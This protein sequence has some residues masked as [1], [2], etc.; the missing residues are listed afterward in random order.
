M[1]EKLLLDCTLRDGGYVNDWNFGHDNLVSVFERVVDAGVDM[2]EIGFLDERRSFDINRSIMPDTDAV[3]RIYGRLDRKNTMVVGMIDYGTCGLEHIRPCEESFLDGIRVIFKK[4]LREPALE[5]CRAL[6]ELGYKVFAQ[7]VSVTSYSDGELLDLIRLANEVRPYAVSMV[8]TYG[9]MHQN[10]L[11]HYFDL[12]NKNLLPEIGL[13][14]HAHNNFQM[15]YANCIAMLSNQIE[16]S[17]VVDGSIYGM[18]KSAGNAPLELIAMHMNNACGKHYQISQ[19]LETIDSNILQFY[20]PATWGYNMF[21]YIAA[22]NDCH[23]SY[24]SYLMNK[25]T[26]SIKSINEILSRLQGDKRLLY[27]RD[28]V[29]SLYVDYQN[30]EVDDKADRKRLSELLADKELLLIGPGTTVQAQRDR[31][32][33]YLSGKHPVVISINYVPAGLK[34]DFIFLSN[35]KRYVQLAS[36]LTQERYTVI[37]TSNVTGTSEGVFAFRLNF[38]SLMDP[39]AEIC[40]N[41]L[42]MLLKALISI[43]CRQVTLAGFDGYSS[44]ASNYFNMSM[45]YDFVKKKADYLNDYTIRFLREISGKLSVRF[46]TDSRYGGADGQI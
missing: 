29:E 17:I 13:G 8:D 15:G 38:S 16:R 33:R 45:E 43:G 36:R 2:I 9:L 42:V 20:H 10:N 3:A 25:R 30:H 5:F 37:A 39:D 12:L 14:Y 32:D 41:S 46:L 26:L 4:H 24:V 1:G 18:G 27:D 31:I 35:A 34:P 19:I 11:M 7:L 6:K 28:Y 21:Y 22:S 23:P 44:E 40:D